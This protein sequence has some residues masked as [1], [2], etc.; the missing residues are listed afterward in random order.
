[1]EVWKSNSLTNENERSRICA[2]PKR[3]EMPKQERRRKE[4]KGSR[5]LAES[6]VGL[7]EKRIALKIVFPPTTPK[8]LIYK[9]QI[10][11]SM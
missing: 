5:K 1:M 8:S 7:A 3:T 10:L 2:A 6:M 4:K 11:L 9:K